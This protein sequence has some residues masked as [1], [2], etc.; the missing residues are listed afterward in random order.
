MALEFSFSQPAF[1]D[2]QLVAVH[3]RQADVGHHEIDLRVRLEQFQSAGAGS[4]RGLTRVELQWKLHVLARGK[5][6]DKIV[7]L[8]NETDLPPDIHQ[9][10]QGNS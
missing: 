8:E 4:L 7:R 9:L 3:P 10:F 2:G 1:L 5:R 6:R